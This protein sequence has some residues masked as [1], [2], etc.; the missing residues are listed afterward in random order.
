MHKIKQAGLF[1]DFTFYFVMHLQYLEKRMKKK[2]IIYVTGNKMK[3]DLL[4]KFLKNMPFEIVQKNIDTPEIQADTV[5]EVAKFSAKYASDKLK[6]DVLI[7]DCGFVVPAL[8]GFPGAYAKYVEQTLGADGIL[9][10][11]KG[12]QNREAYYHDVYAYCPYG[13]SPVVFI[14]Q[15]FGEIAPQKSGTDGYPYDK[16][17]IAKGKTQTMAHLPYEEFL[18]CFDDTGVKQLA[19]YLINTNK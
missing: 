11:M 5:E 15:T 19:E 8:N 10:L 4:N 14:S 1:V 6:C 17:F 2:T 9:A 18:S 12:K 16:V 3:V 7:N 13:K